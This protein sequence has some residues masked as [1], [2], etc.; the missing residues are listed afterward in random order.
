M[1]RL[2]RCRD[3]FGTWLL[4]LGLVLSTATQLRRPEIPIGPGE[5]LLSIWIALGLVRLPARKRLAV[6]SVQ[7]IFGY[8][9]F[10]SFVLLGLGWLVSLNIG[11]WK[12]HHVRD[13]FV[14]AFVAVLVVGVLLQEQL[15]TKIRKG[16]VMVVVVSVVAAGTL[17]VIANGTYELGPLQLWYGPRFRGWAENP[18]Q[19]AM[20]LLLTP[21]FLIGQCPMA[22]RALRL[23][24]GFLL[25]VSLGTGYC[26]RSDALLVA[27]AVA[28]GV[29][30]LLSWFERLR[31]TRRTASVVFTRWVV[32]PTVAALLAI[33]FGSEMLGKIWRS[34][35]GMY[36]EGLQGS[37]RL[38]L[39]ING[40]AAICAS[41]IVGLGPG[42][43]SG[44]IGAFQGYESHNTIIDWGTNTGV[45]GILL[46]VGLFCWLGYRMLKTRNAVGFAAVLS[47]VVF[48]SFHYVL[49]HPIIWY[50]MIA[51][52]VMS[53]CE[54]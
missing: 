15:G 24:F 6:G 12:P 13:L 52:A 26:T 7:R 50:Y 35:E 33:C 30:M 16:S 11:V 46:L 1:D 39:W 29:L 47:L 14:Y 44:G 25:V 42:S 8:F 40:I 23:A 43:H 9:W 37:A 3:R 20:L 27:W 21:F 2:H 54:Y 32:F 49:R 51:L 19:M 45:A 28:F 48:S 34:L 18:N 53:Y 31:S 17:L 22:Q 41:P 38:S 5:V 4:S 36:F 10:V